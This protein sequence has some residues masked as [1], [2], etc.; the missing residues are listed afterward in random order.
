[1]DE[2]RI[3]DALGEKFDLPYFDNFEKTILTTYVKLNPQLD[4]HLVETT[5]NR[6]LSGNK[7]LKLTANSEEKQ[8]CIKILEMFQNTLVNKIIDLIPPKPI[9]T[10]EKVNIY[11]LIVIS[12]ELD[13][14]AIKSHILDKTAPADENFIAPFLSTQIFTYYLEQHYEIK[15]Q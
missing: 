10:S 9:Y 15:S 1:L 4:Y 12:K 7:K 6:K 3:Y 11:F 5:K 8:L 14:Q 2:E 13:Y